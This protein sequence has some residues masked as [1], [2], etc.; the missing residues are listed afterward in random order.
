MPVCKL[1]ILDQEPEEPCKFD[2]S[3]DD[4]G[5]SKHLLPQSPILFLETESKITAPLALEFVF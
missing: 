4:K 2:A 5:G 3:L 1:S